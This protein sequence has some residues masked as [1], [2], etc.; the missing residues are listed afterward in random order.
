MIPLRDDNPT[1]LP[2]VV[3][4]SLIVA[5]TLVFLWQFSQNDFEAQRVVY[6]LGVIPA[7]LFGEAE[8]P[9]EVALVP[10]A[11]TIIT[12]MFLHG[13]WLH[14][15]GNM[16]Y[17]WIFGNNIEDSMGHARFVVFYALCGA[18]AALAQ[19]AVAPASEVPMV[20]ASGAIAG[21]LG[22]Y[23]ILFPHAHVLVLIPLG[24]FSQLIHIPAVI[25][26]GLW[27]VLQFVSGAAQPTEGG[28]VAYWAHVGGFVAGVVLIVPFR[29]RTVP[30]FR[31]RRG[32]WD[33]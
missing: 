26:L 6:A 30:L 2:P 12:S 31:R 10:P 29:H 28:G 13:G 5:C 19:S 23:L 14:L 25:V 1:T 24:F 22:A 18:A 15:I 32:P 7:V 20:G 33:R 9:P 8:L 21:V 27:F 11:L 3:T 17:L 4:V 16:L